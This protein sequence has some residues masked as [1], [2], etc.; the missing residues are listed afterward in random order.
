MYSP[1][2]RPSPSGPPDMIA[3]IRHRAEPAVLEGDRDLAVLAVT[4]LS[5]VFGKVL[6]GADVDPVFVCHVARPRF[7][8]LAL[9]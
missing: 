3:D 7:W 9:D 2:S 8:C 1:S 4:R 5:G 6:G